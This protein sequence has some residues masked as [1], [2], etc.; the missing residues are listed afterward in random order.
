[1][2]RELR[3]RV[4]ANG[5][6]HYDWLIQFSAEYYP[7]TKQ[8]AIKTRCFPFDGIESG[9]FFYGEEVEGIVMQWTG[10]NDKDGTP[11]YDGDIVTM[12]WL[13]FEGTKVGESLMQI[14]YVSFLRNV[15]NPELRRMKVIGNIYE[16]KDLLPDETA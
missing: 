3:F 2:S 1:M 6:M 15:T 14:E 8:T 9:E 5:E 10:F 11:I 4:F 7:L 16:N 13:D 12:D